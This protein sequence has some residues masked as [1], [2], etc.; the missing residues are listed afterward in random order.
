[1]VKTHNIIIHND[2]IELE[3]EI[4][5]SFSIKDIFVL[6]CHPDPR[7]GG[8]FHNNIISGIFKSLISNDISCLRFNF[9]GVGKST[10]SFSNGE[11]ELRDVKSCIDFVIETKEGRKIFLVGYS[12]GALIGCAAINYNDNII[13]FAAISL[14][15]EHYAQKIENLT[16]SDKPKLFVQ[17]DNDNFV[18]LSNFYKYYTSYQE[19]K[20]SLI[21]K[22]ADH[23]YWGFEEKIAS[24]IIKFIL[25]LK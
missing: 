14:P 19:P 22:G 4:Y 20:N 3:A 7:M 1:M 25:S 6:L 15:F 8:N 18:P 5:E 16:R 10:G 13:G 21:I 12:F 23:F 2:Q 17:G 24:E 11:G 9:R